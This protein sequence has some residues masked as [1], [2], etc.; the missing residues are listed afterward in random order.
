MP[1]GSGRVPVLM[2][3]DLLLEPQAVRDAAVGLT[4]DLPTRTLYPGVTATVDQAFAADL[5]TALRPPMQN[6]FGVPAAAPL[7][8][9]GYFGL[10]STPEGELTLRQSIPHV[11]T[12]QAQSLAILY[13]LCD[14]AFGGTGFFRHRATGI[15]TMSDA[16]RPA[17]D[18]A[19][20]TELAGRT[21]AY[22]C[23]DDP[24]FALIGRA[25]A[26]FNRL[27]VYPGN[28]LHSGLV[29]VERLSAD[30]VKGRLTM[31]LFV[32]PG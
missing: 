31:N 9:N 27:L 20:E 2:V 28:L 15:E 4:F 12:T 30:P 18:A 17:Y 24:A 1:V 16:A 21:P 23:A 5:L 13:Y 8:C 26:K 32:T 10:V 22:P 7:A 14:E 11:D 3:D 6:V 19:L 29:A 25:E